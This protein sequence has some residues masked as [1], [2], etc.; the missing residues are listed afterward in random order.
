VAGQIL[1]ARKETKNSWDKVKTGER[2]GD[3]GY[4]EIV[5]RRWH[6][7]VIHTDRHEI[8]LDPCES[9]NHG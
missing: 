1:A 8:L 4:R 6:I 5:A 2:G 7:F 3:C 9:G